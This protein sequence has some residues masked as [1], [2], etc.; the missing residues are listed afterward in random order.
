MDVNAD[1]TIIDKELEKDIYQSIYTLKTGFYLENLKFEENF[2]DIENFI[3][4]FENKNK[5]PEDVAHL[6][7]FKSF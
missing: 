2:E 7:N 5:T 1:E 4:S 6:S 3:E